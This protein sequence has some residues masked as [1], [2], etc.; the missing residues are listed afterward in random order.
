MAGPCLAVY[1]DSTCALRFRFFALVNFE[2]YTVSL[3]VLFSKGR[4]LVNLGHLSTKLAKL[5]KTYHVF[6][7]GSGVKIIQFA[8]KHNFDTPL[9]HIWCNLRLGGRKQHHLSPKSVKNQPVERSN[10]WLS[11]MV[12]VDRCPNSFGKSWFWPH[13]LKFNL[14]KKMNKKHILG[15]G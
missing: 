12:L 6:K 1:V 8:P 10:T 11:K 13:I 5:H 3:T 9:N 15:P 2:L 4:W 7:R 14:L